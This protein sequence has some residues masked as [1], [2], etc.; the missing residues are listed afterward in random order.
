METIQDIWAGDSQAE[1]WVMERKQLGKE[2]GKN[3]QRQRTQR[4]QRP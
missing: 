3:E 2:E 1:T 4:W